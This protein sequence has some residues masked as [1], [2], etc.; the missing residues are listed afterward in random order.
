MNAISMVANR[1]HVAYRVTQLA[2]A[3]VHQYDVIHTQ[4][5]EL[6]F[7]LVKLQCCYTTLCTCVL[8]LPNTLWLKHTGITYPL[9]RPSEKTEDSGLGNSIFR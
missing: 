6:H 8:D 3:D 1:V 7:F 2:I 4:Y 5:L 9:V